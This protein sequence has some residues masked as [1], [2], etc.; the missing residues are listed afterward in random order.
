MRIDTESL[1]RLLVKVRK[2]G[3]YVGGEYNAIVKD[4]DQAAVRVC[5]AFPDI[6]DLGMSNLALAILYDV[7]NRRS[8]VLAERVFLP[9]VDMI[10]AMRQASVPLFSLENRRPLADFDIIGLTIPYEQLYTNVLEMLDLAGI[11]VRSAERSE[12]WPLIIAGGHSTFNPEPMSDFIDA[13]VIGDGEEVILEVLEAF[14]RSREASREEQLLSLVRIPGIYVPRFYDV[15]YEPDGRVH[16]VT[17]SVPEARLPVMKRVVSVLPPPPTRPVVPN[18]NVSHNRATIEIQRGCTRGCRFCQAGVVTRPVRERPVGE[19]LSAIKQIVEETGFE[20]VGLLSLSS[21]DYADI[22]ELVEAIAAQFSGNHLSISLPALRAD[23]FSIRLADAMAGGRH[24]GFTFAPE[25][26]TDHLRGVINKPITSSQMLKVASEVFERGWR[27][28]KLYFMI[29][30]PGEQMA[31]VE[32][33]VDLVYAVRKIGRQVHGR[34]SQ[35]NVSINTFVPKPHTPFQWVGSEPA[36]SIR[37]KHMY[38]RRRLTGKG[39][40]FRYSDGDLTFLESLLSRG[41]RRLGQVI[42]RAWQRGARFDAWH[43]QRSFAA[44]EQALEDSGVDPDFYIRRERAGDEMLPWE[45]VGTGV[46]KEYLL[47]EYRRSQQG[48]LRP[49]CRTGCYGCGILSA[50]GDAW[51]EEWCCPKP[52]GRGGG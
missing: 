10:D 19:V 40:K 2:P 44:W 31:D 35:I 18:I 39:L 50:Y 32:A 14:R 23:S 1:E 47:A 49:D 43:E 25:A 29:G 51:A 33:I 26:A 22:G 46:R 5:L 7:L 9:W 42:Y 6:Y 38:L 17:P 12:E 8:D 27:T 45:V 15:S 16:A 28:V 48:E 37:Q 30:L 4:W 3:R 34:K 21:S 11:P 20:E 13:F 36:D 52:P 24:S 41:D